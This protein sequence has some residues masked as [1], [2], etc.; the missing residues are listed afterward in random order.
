[1][2]INPIRNISLKNVP[3]PVNW[4]T[5]KL[6][7]CDF[8]GCDKFFSMRCL[9]YFVKALYGA[10]DT[11]LPFSSSHSDCWSSI[12]QTASTRWCCAVKTAPLQTPGLPPSTPTSPPCCHRSWLTSTPTWEPRHHPPH[13]PISN[14][15]AGWL[16]RYL[17]LLLL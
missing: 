5:P 9:H 12:P 1:M 16:N 14:T 2:K 15:S 3:Q 6:R 10:A 4:V 13:T 17:R 8:C 11:V 7:N